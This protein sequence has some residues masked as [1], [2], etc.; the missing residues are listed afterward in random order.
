VFEAIRF[1]LQRLICGVVEVKS[2]WSCV[3]EIVGIVF[4]EIGMSFLF[5]GINIHCWVDLLVL[6]LSS[7]S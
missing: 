6:G 1:H 5:E 7:C 4:Q 3:L 2:T